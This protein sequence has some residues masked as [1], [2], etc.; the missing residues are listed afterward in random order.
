MRYIY[1][2]FNIFVVVNFYGI[3]DQDY[4]SLTIFSIYD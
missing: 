3:R 1:S 2:K 4:L